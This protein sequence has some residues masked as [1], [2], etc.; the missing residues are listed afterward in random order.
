M[1]LYKAKYSDKK[2]DRHSKS[3]TT[4]SRKSNEDNS[5]R[6]Y[7]NTRDE[8]KPEMHTVTCYDCGNE[9]KIPFEPKFNRPV[10]CSECFQKNNPRESRD[11]YSK[12]DR[13]SRDKY[14]KDDSSSKTNQDNYKTSKFTSKKSQ[15]KTD[16]F[17]SNGSEKF[18]SSLKE[19]L[20]EILGGK[21]CSNCGFN[22][23]RALGFNHISDVDAFDS[24]RRGG[25]AS[26]WGKYISEPELARKDL[27][28]L[29]L[30][31]NEIRDFPTKTEPQKPKIF[32]KKSRYFPS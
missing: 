32:Y 24:I 15:S 3:N 11:K 1:D 14:S 19:K 28:V 25:F 26:S 7:R 16:N 4:S 23:E 21:L 29:C 10:Y 31:C 17:Y 30:N 8:R 20:F 9:C 18:Y 6:S 5:I 2:F 12:D 22:D 27:R 13:P